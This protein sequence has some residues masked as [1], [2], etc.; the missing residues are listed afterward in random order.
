MSL[1]TTALACAPVL[2]VASSV[3]AQNRPGDSLTPLQMAVACQSP[4][5]VVAEPVDAVRIA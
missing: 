1:R 2:L 4:P 3:S 5:V